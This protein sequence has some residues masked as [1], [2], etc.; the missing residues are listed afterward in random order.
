MTWGCRGALGAIAVQDRL[1]YVKLM[2]QLIG[3]DFRSVVKTYW[4]RYCPFKPF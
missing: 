3:Q 2:Q 1:A 4:G